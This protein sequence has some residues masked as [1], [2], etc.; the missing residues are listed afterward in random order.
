MIPLTIRPE[1]PEDIDK[2]DNLVRNTF[3]NRYQPGCTEH[4]L[5]RR[6][7]VS[8]IWSRKLSAL[9]VTDDQ[10]IG[11]IYFSE[12]T[13]HTPAGMLPVLTCGPLAV[14][15]DFQK[16]GIGTTLLQKKIEEAKKPTTLQFF[17]T[18]I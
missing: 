2:I 10:I 8:P 4:L 16:R 12:G 17:F 15:P 18:V 13:I 1:Q 9:A 11:L 14:D 5:V 6:L 3:W 7:R